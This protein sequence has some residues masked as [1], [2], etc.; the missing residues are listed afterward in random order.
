MKWVLVVLLVLLLTA[1]AQ[2]YLSKATIMIKAVVPS[3][4]I[5]EIDDGETLHIKSNDDW[6]LVINDITYSGIMGEW[7]IKLNPI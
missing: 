1:C 6:E 5:W 2:S 3:M 7:W 4:I